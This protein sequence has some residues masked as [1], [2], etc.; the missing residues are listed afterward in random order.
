MS[1]VFNHKFRRKCSTSL[2]L[3]PQHRRK[4]E[5]P[6]RRPNFVF[7]TFRFGQGFGE[8]CLT[9]HHRIPSGTQHQIG[10]CL[11]ATAP[12]SMHCFVFFPTNGNNTKKTKSASRE[13]THPSEHQHAPQRRRATSMRWWWERFAESVIRDDKQLNHLNVWG[14]N[15]SARWHRFRKATTWVVQVSSE[16]QDASHLSVELKKTTGQE[17]IL[18][19]EGEI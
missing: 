5:I 17:R 18:A 10:S 12:C 14:S 13:A 9:F 3:P 16:V 15:L 7:V 11:F 19:R 8:Q 4:P 6:P 1:G 2:L